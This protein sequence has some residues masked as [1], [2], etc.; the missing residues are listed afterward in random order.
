MFLETVV[1]QL[2][3]PQNKRKTNKIKPVVFQHEVPL[4]W[5]L[6]NK[7]NNRKALTLHLQHFVGSTPLSPS[8]LSRKIYKQIIRRTIEMFKEKQEIIHH[9]RSIR[10]NITYLTFSDLYLSMNWFLKLYSTLSSINN[11]KNNS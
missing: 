2:I 3:S 4:F 7:A 8:W 10:Y 11:N 5:F 6:S 1:E 9:L